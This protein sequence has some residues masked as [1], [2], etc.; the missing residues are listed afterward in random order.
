[1]Q[2]LESE[3]MRAMSLTG[4]WIDKNSGRV[5]F[6]FPNSP[7]QSFYPDGP[8]I[9]S[10]DKI[11]TDE[12][13]PVPIFCGGYLAQQLISRY[14]KYISEELMDKYHLMDWNL[15][16]YPQFRE[17]GM[18]STVL[19]N[20]ERLFS[21]VMA[22]MEENTEIEDMLMSCHIEHEVVC[23]WSAKMGIDLV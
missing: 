18:Q 23:S 12:Y 22:M 11:N 5:Y 9:K 13:I 14:R 16:N 10:R 4:G 1:M 6:D 20:G 3:L 21:N 8:I 17:K 19:D 15:Y 2:V 7:P